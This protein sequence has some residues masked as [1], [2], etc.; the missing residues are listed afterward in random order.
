MRLTIFL[1]FVLIAA[2]FALSPDCPSYTQ[3]NTCTPKCKEDI[4]CASSGGKCCPNIC[5]TRSCVS[6]QNNSKFGSNSGDK[7]GSNSATGSYC[8]NVKCSSFEKCGTDP[9]SKKPKCVRS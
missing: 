5:S 4:E 7:Y 8:G 1:V 2:T 9:S 6:R 3:V